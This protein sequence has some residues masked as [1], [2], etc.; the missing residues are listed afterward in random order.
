LKAPSK[1]LFLFHQ[2]MI[3]PPALNPGDKVAIVSPARKLPKDDVD[4]AM[5]V[6]EGWGLVVEQGKNILSNAHSYLSGTDKERLADLQTAIDDPTV[7]AIFCARGGYGTTRIID[8]L[9]LTALQRRHKWIVGFSDITSLHLLL[10]K[11][12]FESIHGTMP[13]LF[14]KPAAAS[15]VQNLRQLIF[16]ADFELAANSSI[17]NI[18]GDATGSLV[19]GNL[20]LIVE[21]LGTATS[22]D[23]DGCILVIEEID[24]FKYRVDRMLNTL[25]RAGKLSNL[26]GLVVG[27]MTSISDSE[28]P[29]G[30]TTYE[31]VLN[32][33]RDYNY[34]VAFNFPTGHDQ[35]NYPWIHG[36]AARL[37]VKA[38]GALLTGSDGSPKEKI[39]QS[40]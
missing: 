24:E 9:D 3:K 26:H 23:T 8:Q 36:A 32:A 10:Y 18:Q 30:E 13:V 5:S 28:L 35:P 16:G 25:R 7:S 14:Q 6:L 17:H 33:V 31:M 2:I 15:S 1:G 29:F 4:Y 19:G 34:P 37:S 40:I 38:G 11:N 20:S 12:G 21:S 22:P 39:Q 27:H